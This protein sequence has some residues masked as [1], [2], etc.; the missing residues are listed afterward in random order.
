MVH[1]TELVRISIRLT[2]F[3]ITKR[4]LLLC[5]IIWSLRNILLFQYR[6]FF[7][8]SFWDRVSSKACNYTGKMLWKR[9]FLRRKKSLLREK[10]N[11]TV[12]YFLLIG[13]WENP[14]LCLLNNS[15]FKQFDFGFL[16][17]DIASLNKTNPDDPEGRHRAHRRNCS[18]CSPSRK[19]NVSFASR[20]SVPRYF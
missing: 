4:Y 1:S 10:K 13:Q 19:Q 2:E 20:F 3:L 15:N 12:R 14:T 6:G 5:K 9:R 8:S 16:V 11:W 18:L 7:T 17:R